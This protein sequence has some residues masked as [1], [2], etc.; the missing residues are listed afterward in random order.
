MKR[1][2][3]MVG[4]AMFLPAFLCAVMVCGTSAK[5]NQHLL[6]PS[7][8][9]IGELA[10]THSPEVPTELLRFKS[11]DTRDN[12]E[13]MFSSSALFNYTHRTVIVYVGELI[14]QSPPEQPL[15]IVFMMLGGKKV[16]L[17][18]RKF[19]KTGDVRT[20]IYEPL[21]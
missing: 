13:A 7:H 4:S 8:V 19:A 2:Y 3:L 11:I 20:S 5:S 18:L 21:M 14:E 6:L 1:Y 10:I 17:N 15:E 9:E 12:P 16:H